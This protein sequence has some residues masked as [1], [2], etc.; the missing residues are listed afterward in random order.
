MK[1]VPLLGHTRSRQI[2]A[3]HNDRAITLAQFLAD[4]QTLV[5]LMPAG[6]HIFNMCTDRYFFAVSLAGAVCTGR[7]TFLPATHTPEMVRQM[8]A[9]APDLFCLHNTA[10][11]PVDLPQ[12]TFPA[13]IALPDPPILT[14][15]EAKNDTPC[16]VPLID[17][18]QLVAIVFTSGST[19]IP[20]PHRKYW[21]TLQKSIQA[22]SERI[23]LPDY[24]E[25]CT[26]VGTVPSQHMYGLESTVLIAMQSGHAL[27]SAQ[28]FYPADIVLALAQVPA[29][30]VLVSTPIH[31]RMLLESGLELPT[32][33]SVLSATAPLSPSLA[34]DVE[35]RLNAP[36][37]EIYGSTETGTIATRR[38]TQTQE[39][40]LFNDLQLIQKNDQT[41]A[42]GG[43]ALGS[44][45][46]NDVIEFTR[47]QH[48]LLHGRTADLINIAGK[49]SSLSH[50]NHVLNSIPGVLDGTFYMPDEASPDYQVRLMACVVAPS[51]TSAQIMTALRELVAP[52]FLP[53]PLLRVTS[54]PRNSTGKLPRDALKT[55]FQTQLDK[56]GV[57]KHA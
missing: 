42:T 56:R 53:R 35:T 50:L 19:G 49:R 51:L 33:S 1:Q 28:P 39:W 46:M 57:G 47:N 14:E 55:V 37:N 52:I 44:V 22:E 17:S 20:V 13:L 32:V 23:G 43:Q 27:C 26:I 21:G 2:V 38:T 9:F 25:A 7:V 31:L 29:P 6:Q 3:W 34:H 4:V 12:I 24:K 41:I 54:L 40:H 48:F 11:C 5:N 10:H 18:E 8:Q 30:R 36:L 16:A 45:V 15:V